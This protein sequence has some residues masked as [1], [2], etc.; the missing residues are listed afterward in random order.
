M[1]G[2][3]GYA[4]RDEGYR[5]NYGC[6]QKDVVSSGDFPGG[7]FMENGNMVKVAKFHEIGKDTDGSV[8]LALTASCKNCP[9]YK[10]RP[11]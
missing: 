11:V 6:E 8:I 3:E 9:F 5:E 10:K 1:G 2:E 7:S 4:L